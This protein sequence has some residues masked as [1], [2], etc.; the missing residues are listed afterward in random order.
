M[1][2]MGLKVSVVI[3][4]KNEEEN[5]VDCIE[6]SDFADEIILIDDFSCDRTIEIARNLSNQRVRIF[7]RNLENNFSGQRNFGLSKAKFEWILFLDADE[8][9]SKNLAEEIKCVISN[10]SEINGFYIKRSDFMWSQKLRHGETTNVNLLRLAK[11][12]KGVWKG[13]VHERWIVKGKSDT[14]KNELQHYP[15]QTIYQFLKEINY[16]S[17]LRAKELHDEAKK[18]RLSSIIIYPLAKFIVNYFV[19]AGFLDG[20]RGFIFAV[21]MSFHSFLVRSKLW[22]FYIKQTRAS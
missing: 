14:L 16:Y 4:C 13:K 19:R 21:M 15:H 5:I 9:V 1:K 18:S 22:L 12:D 6:S 17:S 11:K 3:I 8:R 10:K 2:N 7:K 20:L